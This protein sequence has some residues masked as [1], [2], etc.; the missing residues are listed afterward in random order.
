MILNEETF[1]ISELRGTYGIGG[2]DLSSTTDLTCATCLIVKDGIKYVLQ[3]YFIPSQHLQRKIVE[4]NDVNEEYIFEIL[5][6]VG[7][8]PLPPYI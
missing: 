4:D 1:D 5:D 7:N 6:K 8:I 3:Q 2:A